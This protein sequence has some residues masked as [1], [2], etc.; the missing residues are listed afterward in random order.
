MTTNFTIIHS[1]TQIRLLA[2]SCI[3]YI[4]PAILDRCLILR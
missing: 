4:S 3:D 2:A 1:F